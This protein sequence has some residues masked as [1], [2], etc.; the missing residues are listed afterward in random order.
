MRGLPLAAPNQA[1]P[2]VSAFL[3]GFSR[4][5]LS[6][7]TRSSWSSGVTAFALLRLPGLQAGELLKCGKCVKTWVGRGLLPISVE[8]PRLSPQLRPVGRFRASLVL[9]RW[10]WS[11]APCSLFRAFAPKT[12]LWAT[13]L[14]CVLVSFLVDP[15][16]KGPMRFPSLL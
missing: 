9:S 11:V 8:T 7:R 1:A 6:F 14:S 10:Q 16:I 3:G 4:V 13:G 5:R 12:R 15:G 2:D